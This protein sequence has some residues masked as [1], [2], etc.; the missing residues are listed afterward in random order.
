MRSPEFCPNPE[1]EYHLRPPSEFIW[2]RL[3]GSYKT[4]LNGKVQ[5]FRCVRCGRTFSEQTFSLDYYVK[6]KVSYR[7]I[8]EH[9]NSRVGIRKTGRLLGVSHQCI[10]NRIRRLNRLGEAG[11]RPADEAQDLPR[12]AWKLHREGLRSAA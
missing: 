4:K 1:C 11:L 5:R 10:S 12:E 8:L 3:I 2:Y 9:I 7:E 6:R